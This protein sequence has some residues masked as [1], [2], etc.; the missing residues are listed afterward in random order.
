MF[1]DALVRDAARLLEDLK[2][3]R[4]MVVTAESCTGGLIAALLT[5]SPGSSSVLE[6]GFITYSNEAKAEL[7]GIDP[8]LIARVGAV[9]REVALA[10]AEGAIAR[11][12]AQVSVAVTGVAGPGGGTVSK[13]VGLVHVAAARRGEPTLAEECR[14]GE[15]SRG[16]IRMLTVTAALALLRRASCR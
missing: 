10:M 6:R 11:S 12:R 4:L 14:F 1:T 13:P 15:L 3:A 7:L 16:E 9:S 2:Q 5:E 8:A